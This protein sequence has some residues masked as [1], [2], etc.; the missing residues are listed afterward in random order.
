MIDPADILGLRGR[1][2]LVTGG[3]RG[4]GRAVALVLTRAGAEVGVAYRSRGQDAEDLVARVR[5]LGGRGW[6]HSGDLRDPEVVARLFDVF[7][8]E[9]GGVDV[10]VGNHGVWPADHVPLAR[11]ELD[12]WR[13]TLEINL[14]GMFLVCREAARRLT[15]GGRLIVVT[16]TAA[17]RG[18]AGHGDYAA[19]K[20]ALNSLV[21]GLAEE[22]GVRGITVNAVAPGWVDTEMTES[23]LVGERRARAIGE[24]PL[25]RIARPEDVAGP[26]VFLASELGRHVT[27]EILNVNGGSV[28]PG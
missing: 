19:S 21:K 25:G 7:E 12:Q 28:R 23:V 26:V 24:I 10:V 9:Y 16:S 5:Q 15:A 1:R 18:E 11:M 6:S 13:R 27:G 14:D 22:L 17:Q 3:S 20:G 8:A 4:V 2:V